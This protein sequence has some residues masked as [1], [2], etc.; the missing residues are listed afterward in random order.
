MPWSG[1]G[2]PEMA[3]FSWCTN[4]ENQRELR[5]SGKFPEAFEAALGGERAVLLHHLPHLKGLLQDLI[6]FLHRGA[7][8]AGDAFAPL[9]VDQAM[10]VALGVC[11]RVDDGLD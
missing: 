7:A 11:H 9:A 1:P 3:P 8:A 5:R 10:V 2:F 6:D 4:H